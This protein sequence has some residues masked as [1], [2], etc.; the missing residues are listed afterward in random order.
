M[1]ACQRER[2]AGLTER[3]VDV[4]IGFH[5][6]R[7]NRGAFQNSNWARAGQH[8]GDPQTAIHG[9]PGAPGRRGRIASGAR[10]TAPALASFQPRNVRFHYP[11]FDLNAQSLCAEFCTTLHAVS[12][13]RSSVGAI[14]DSLMLTGVNGGP[15]D[16]ERARPQ[17]NE[18]PTFRWLPS[19]S[20]TESGTR[21][22]RRQLTC[23]SFMGC[24]AVNAP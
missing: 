8:G 17:C 7:T 22:M 14:N 18:C 3:H 21:S 12:G 11:A 15:K 6:T 5:Q 19:S 20:Q 24:F 13:Y 2:E 1:G 4:S 9:S 23:F 16:R 10:K